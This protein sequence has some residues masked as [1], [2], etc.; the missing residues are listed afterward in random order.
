[1]DCSETG[2]KLYLKK[3]CGF[4]DLNNMIGKKRDI[5]I[6]NSSKAGSFGKKEL[7]WSG[8]EKIGLNG[9]VVRNRMEGTMH[10]EIEV[11]KEI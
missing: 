7:N 5:S 1:M 9:K 6:R 8:Q 11:V 3:K 10:K 2:R 4:T